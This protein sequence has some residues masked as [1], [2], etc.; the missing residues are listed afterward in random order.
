MTSTRALSPRGS[1]PRDSL[2]QLVIKLMV[3]VIA[4]NTNLVLHCLSRNTASEAH[5]VSLRPIFE[6]QSVITLLFWVRFGAAPG[7]KETGAWHG[8]STS[9][10]VALVHTEKQPDERLHR[11]WAKARSDLLFFPKVLRFRA[12]SHDP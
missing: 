4:R 10:L 9:L 1:P 6:I 2:R 12:R 11:Y 3:P 5:T 7:G 8:E